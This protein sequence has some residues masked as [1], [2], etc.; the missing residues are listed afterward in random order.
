MKKTQKRKKR[1]GVVVLAICVAALAVVLAASVLVFSCQTPALGAAASPPAPAG[2]EQPAANDE[3]TFTI[4]SFNIQ[5]FG[6][7]KMAKTGVAAVLAE[8]LSKA[9]VAAIQE[10]RSAS[11]EPV[12]RFMSLLPDR[13][14]WV[15]GPREGRTSS[16]EQYWIIYD[17]ERLD[18]LDSALFPDDG[19][20]FEREPLGALMAARDGGFDFVLVDCHLRPEGAAEE[21]AALP[22]VAAYFRERWGEEDVLILGDFNADG[23]YYDEAL[24]EEVFPGWR[25]IIGNNMDTTVSATENTYDR[26]VI[27]PSADED[28]SGRF[29]VLR[30]D[31]EL[32]LGGIRPRDLSDHY[33]VWAE[34]YTARDTD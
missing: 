33:P 2:G 23:A 27:S 8:I 11:P 22:G 30:F 6:V 16:K 14:D 4:F 10:V 24:L 18:A 12:E 20:V 34:F 17:A 13:Y 29:G 7:S 1:N 19:D 25:I 5:I 9:D 3:E 21:I 31:E 15:L 28:F 26:F 32:D